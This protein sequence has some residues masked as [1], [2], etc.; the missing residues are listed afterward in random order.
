MANALGP[1]HCLA[2]LMFHAFTGCD[3]VS[4][5]GGR[6][7]KTTWEIM[8]V[9]EDFTPAFCTLISCPSVETIENYLR[10]LERFDVLLYDLTS[11]KEQFNESRK[12]ALYLQW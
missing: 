10:L 9:Y 4:I 11:D 12:E 8:K 1:Q 5:F 6:G 2:L 3:T 7:K